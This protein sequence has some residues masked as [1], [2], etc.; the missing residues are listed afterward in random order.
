VCRG[1]RQVFWAL[2]KV[3]G[4]IRVIFDVRVLPWGPGEGAMFL[5]IRLLRFVPAGTT[6]NAKVSLQSFYDTFY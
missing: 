2:S 1:L 6:G 5:S 4:E 3:R